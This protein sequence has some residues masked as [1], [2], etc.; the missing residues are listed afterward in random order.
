M[1]SLKVKTMLSDD[2]LILQIKKNN[3]EALELLFFKYEINFNFLIKKMGNY[4]KPL[5]YDK[6]DLKIIMKTN[7]L[8]IIK[9]YDI[10]KA[11]F[12]AFWIL[13]EKR[14]LIK[15]YREKNVDI[16]SSITNTSL[17][18]Q[19]SDFILNKYLV[20]TPLEKY[21]MKDDYNFFINKIE[22]NVGEYYKKILLLWSKGYSYN[23]I[24]KIYNITPIQVNNYIQKCF[25]IIKKMENKLKF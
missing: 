15:I 22:E 11:C 17:D 20:E 16:K 24:A 7:M 3:L 4:F 6:E 25:N 21:I 18:E 8:N 19:K 23:E 12:S 2:E 10:N 14:H 5:N 13:M 9:L 1:L